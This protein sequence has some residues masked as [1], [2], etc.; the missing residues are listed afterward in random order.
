[1][2]A[3]I[4]NLDEVA[5]QQED[6]SL[7][8][9]LDGRQYATREVGPAEEEAIRVAGET[10]D[11]AAGLDALRKLFVEPPPDMDRWRRDRV[12]MVVT[13]VLTYR[14]VRVNALTDAAGRRVAEQYRG[15]SQNRK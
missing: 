14:R 7:I 6:W 13:T 8:L 2:I 15:L 5:R 4:V 11:E 9:Q 3:M 1:V 10:A 12:A